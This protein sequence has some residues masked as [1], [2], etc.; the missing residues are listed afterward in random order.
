MANPP[1]VISRE[2]W[3]ISV[4]VLRY[5]LPFRVMASTMICNGTLGLANRKSFAFRMYLVS[6]QN[7]NHVVQPGYSVTLT[8]ETLRPNDPNNFNAEFL[9]G[10]IAHRRA[11]LFSVGFYYRR[12]A[13][14]VSGSDVGSRRRRPAGRSTDEDHR[15]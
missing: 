14:F 5:V 9:G 7:R 6:L 8:A 3:L 13:A 11:I 10:H 1:D 15:P 12:C 4:R 2:I